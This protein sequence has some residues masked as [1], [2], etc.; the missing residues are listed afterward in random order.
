MPGDERQREVPLD[1][2][3]QVEQV[4]GAYYAGDRD[5]VVLVIDEARLRSEVRSEPVPGFDTPLPHIYGPL[6]PDAVIDTM[7]LVATRHG[8][9]RFQPAGPDR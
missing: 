6:N 2:V 8:R 4:A 9:F 3:W 1:G 7:P 5:L